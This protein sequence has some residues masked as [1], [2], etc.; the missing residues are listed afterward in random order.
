MMQSFTKGFNSTNKGDH[1][2]MSNTNKNTLQNNFKIHRRKNSFF[3][4]TQE[5]SKEVTAK[6][7]LENNCHKDGLSPINTRE[8]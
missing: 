4:Q 6:E 1:S 5:P 2:T 8:A 3:E 7:K